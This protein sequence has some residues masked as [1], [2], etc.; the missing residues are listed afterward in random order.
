MSTAE[1]ARFLGMTPNALRNAVARKVISPTGRLGQRF[2]WTESHIRQQVELGVASAPRQQSVEAEPLQGLA[3]KHVGSA[4]ESRDEQRVPQERRSQIAAAQK[5]NPPS[6]RGP[7]PIDPRDP[8]GLRAAL[9]A[10][11]P[12][13]TQS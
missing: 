8:F 6:R 9:A 7:A 2:L 13:T 12:G 4:E 10:V 11:F 3:A 1:A 5:A